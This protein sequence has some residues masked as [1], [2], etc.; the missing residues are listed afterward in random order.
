MQIAANRGDVSTVDLLAQN[1][2]EG[3]V[4]DLQAR[5]K[6]VVSSFLTDLPSSS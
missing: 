3:I 1:E 4:K 6:F 5:L 2:E